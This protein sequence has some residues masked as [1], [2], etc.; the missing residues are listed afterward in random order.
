MRAKPFSCRCSTMTLMSVVV[1][2]LSTLLGV[3]L[4]RALGMLIRWGMRRWRKREPGWW[5]VHEWRPN[6]PSL[7]RK[8]VESSVAEQSDEERRPLL[9]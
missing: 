2:V 7:R 9:D 4:I 3:I 1:A 5:R 6:L 8:R